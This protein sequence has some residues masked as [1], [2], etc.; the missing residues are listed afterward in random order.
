MGLR[1]APAKDTH[2]DPHSKSNKSNPIIMN[3]R[4]VKLY[5]EE[6]SRG[7]FFHL[8][9][10]YLQEGK[11]RRV[12]DFNDQQKKRCALCDAKLISLNDVLAIVEKNAGESALQIALSSMKAK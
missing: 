7:F 9:K 12:I 3:E 1:S 5:E 2:V 6:E 10:S 11:T 4:I 8:V